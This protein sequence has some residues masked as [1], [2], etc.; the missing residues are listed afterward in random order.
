MQCVL[1]TDRNKWKKESRIFEAIIRFRAKR[2]LL[3]YSEVRFRP[4]SDSKKKNK[5]PSW[6]SKFLHQTGSNDGVTNFNL[7]N[8][9]F[10]VMNLISLKTNQI[11]RSENKFSMNSRICTEK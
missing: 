10:S 11:F 5:Q 3:K 1:I 4:E 8:N 2:T 6:G 9:S 7:K